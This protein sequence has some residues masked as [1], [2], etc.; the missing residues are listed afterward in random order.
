M[1]LVLFV[2]MVL[3][4]VGVTFKSLVKVF[5]L[6]VPFIFKKRIQQNEEIR[7]ANVQQLKDMGIEVLS[8]EDYPTNYTSIR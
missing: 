4:L 3:V 6:T 8:D 7:M 1:E 5:E 2:L